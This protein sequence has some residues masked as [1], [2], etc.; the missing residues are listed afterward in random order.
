MTTCRLRRTL[1]FSGAEKG[2]AFPAKGTSGGKA[3]MQESLWHVP[4]TR[5]SSTHRASWARDKGHG[6]RAEIGKGQTVKTW[7]PWQCLEIIPRKMRNPGELK[8]GG[9]LC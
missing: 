6:V 1:S 3:W 2:M 7:C 8:V 9:H 5:R 4:G